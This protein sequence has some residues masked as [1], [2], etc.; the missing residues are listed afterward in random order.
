ML[1]LGR[2]EGWFSHELNPGYDWTT[3]MPHLG[4]SSILPPFLENLC[5]H[6]ASTRLSDEMVFLRDFVNESIGLPALQKLKI[7]GK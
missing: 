3:S 6:A 2:P 4:L 1:L 7:R 5:L